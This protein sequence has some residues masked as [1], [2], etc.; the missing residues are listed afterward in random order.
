[1]INGKKREKHHKIT[2]GNKTQKFI[3]AYMPLTF[4][5][6]QMSTV[7]MMNGK[8][9]GSVEGESKVRCCKSISLRSGVRSYNAKIFA[10]YLELYKC[11]SQSEI[12]IVCQIIVV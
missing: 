12:V 7:Q 6:N 10:D 9:L 2:K 5:L 3:Y 8:C 11:S 1:M 4:H